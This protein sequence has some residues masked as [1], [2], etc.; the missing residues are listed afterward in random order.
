M[1]VVPPQSIEQ[2]FTISQAKWLNKISNLVGAVVGAVALLDQSGA[3]ALLPARLQRYV[4]P[5]ALTTGV[6]ALFVGQKK[7]GAALIANHSG[8]SYVYT[9]DGKPG[10]DKK[11]ALHQVFMTAAE[12]AIAQKATSGELVPVQTQ[13]Q[14]EERILGRLNEFKPMSFLADSGVALP[15]VEM[16][17]TAHFS[18]NPVPTQ[19]PGLAELTR[20]CKVSLSD[21]TA[22]SQ[23][24][25]TNIFKNPQDAI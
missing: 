16:G 19:T 6:I 13:Q 1:D 23:N 24:Q 2:S 15:P 25:T 7:Q 18:P 12:V 21:L 10:R 11:D 14:F 8:R 3:F 17:V 20:G 22:T 4:T 9:P 5:L